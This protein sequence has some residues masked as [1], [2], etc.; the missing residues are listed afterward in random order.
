LQSTHGP[1][2]SRVGAR[3]GKAVRRI[4]RESSGSSLD[5]PA[6]ARKPRNGRKPTTRTHPETPR[7]VSPARPS[8]PARN[9]RAS[10]S[11]VEL[12]VF[13]DPLHVVVRRPPCGFAEQ[14]QRP[15][16][17][18]MWF[19]GGA[20]AVANPPGNAT[21]I[22]RSHRLLPRGLV[23]ALVPKTRSRL[24]Q[25]LQPSPLGA[26]GRFRCLLRPALPRTACLSKRH[27]EKFRRCTTSTPAT[28]GPGQ[29]ARMGRAVRQFRGTNACPAAPVPPPR[30]LVL[31]AATG[32]PVATLLA[33]C[34]AGTRSSSPSKPRMMTRRSCQGRAGMA[35]SNA[36]PSTGEGPRPD[37]ARPNG[38]GRV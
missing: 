7:P 1:C 26:D 6:G 3:C 2:G 12:P 10:D 8:A 32:T 25:G 15:K 19:A 34:A 35:I 20:A 37:S 28:R 27:G 29:G 30:H 23:R 4:G 13:E 17:R 16:A 18:L 36:A 38:D 11:S 33:R 9:K 14:H 5:A 22:F 24:P 31:D 21:R